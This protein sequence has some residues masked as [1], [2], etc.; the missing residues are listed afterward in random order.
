M[1]KSFEKYAMGINKNTRVRI[2]RTG[3]ASGKFCP[4]ALYKS[5]LR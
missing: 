4:N 2:C 1:E 3:Y 5:Q